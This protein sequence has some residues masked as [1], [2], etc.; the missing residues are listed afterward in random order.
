MHQRGVAVTSNDPVHGVLTYVGVLS[1]LIAMWFG[2]MA[3]GRWFRVYSIGTLVVCLAFAVLTG[4]DIPRIAADQPTRWMG[5][6]ER[7]TIFGYLPVYFLSAG[8]ATLAA[9]RVLMVWVYD[10]TGSLLVATLMHASY[11]FSTLFVLAPPTTGVPF[12][13]YSG[14]FMAVP[15]V[16]VAVVV[17]A[18]PG[19]PRQPS[20]SWGP[21]RAV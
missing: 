19:E 13:T 2:A 10:R 9:Y 11:I 14:V 5:V 1:F 21:S 4:L 12:L 8:F 16:V 18:N 15:W 7:I 17:R 20:A 6:W 3:F